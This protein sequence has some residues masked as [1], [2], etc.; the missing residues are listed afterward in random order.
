MFLPLRIDVTRLANDD[1]VQALVSLF[2]PSFT[3]NQLHQACPSLLQQPSYI[4]REF[5]E[6]NAMAQHFYGTAFSSDTYGVL[7]LN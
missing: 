3:N 7:R 4:L 5:L 2:P 6:S 1:K